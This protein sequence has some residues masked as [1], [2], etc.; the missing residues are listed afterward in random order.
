MCELL[1][2]V[3]GQYGDDSVDALPTFGALSVSSKGGVFTSL[4]NSSLGLVA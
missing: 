4:K 3:I 1:E 2:S